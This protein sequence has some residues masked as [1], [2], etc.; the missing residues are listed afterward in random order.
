M[1]SVLK[2][3]NWGFALLLLVAAVL[4]GFSQQH[5]GL[6]SA[7]IVILGLVM[8]YWGFERSPVSAREIAVIAVLAA[9]AAAGRIP[10]AALPNIQPT[11][12]VVIVAGFAFGPRAGFMVGATAALVSN[13]FLGQGPWTPFQMFAWGLAGVTAGF[14]RTV[15]PQATRAEM[16]LFSFIWGYLFGI[17][18]TLWFWTAFVRPLNLQ[19]FFAAYAAG[20]WFDTLHAVGNAAFYLLLGR[21]FTRIL[22]RYARRLRVEFVPDGKERAG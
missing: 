19:S 18:L 7:G 17:I 4:L 21:Q 2:G 1:P 10:F 20:F 22:T 6:V 14:L 11:T 9:L 16:C 13:F 3:T 5:W 8:L 12:F 15:R